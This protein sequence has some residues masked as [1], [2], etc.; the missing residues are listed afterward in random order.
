MIREAKDGIRMLAFTF[1]LAGTN[2]VPVAEAICEARQ[3]KVPVSLVIDKAWGTGA[4]M[5]NL[6][7]TVQQLL[8]F[9]VQVR[10]SPGQKRLHSK[11]MLADN[12]MS[13]G[14]CNWTA[15]SQTQIERVA[16]LKLSGS[17]AEREATIFD[18]LFAAGSEWDLHRPTPSK[19]FDS[20]AEGGES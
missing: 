5:K 15:N 13:I 4:S 18:E 16:I 12:L 1:D 3:R 7:P 14:S 17:E 2:L 19:S 20:L 6:R 8:R 11:T 9:G 10:T